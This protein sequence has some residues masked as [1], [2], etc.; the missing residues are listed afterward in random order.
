[1]TK[2][3]ICDKKVKSLYLQDQK[4]WVCEKCLN[5]EKI[6]NKKTKRRKT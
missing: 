5:E 4:Y 2:C 1:M 6:K 3:D